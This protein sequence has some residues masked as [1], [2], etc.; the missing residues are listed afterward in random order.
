MHRR[1]QAMLA[2][3]AR[4]DLLMDR[5]AFQVLSGPLPSLLGSDESQSF[6]GERIGVYQLTREL[7]RGGIRFISPMTRDSGATRR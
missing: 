4:D 3:D 1:L 2:A 6:S 7:G 5:P